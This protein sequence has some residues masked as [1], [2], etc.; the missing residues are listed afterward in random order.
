MPIWLILTLIF[1]SLEVIAVSKSLNRLEYVAKPAVMLCLFIWLYV[2]TGLQGKTFWFGVGLLFSLAGDVLLLS[3]GD[4][5]FLLGLIAF[6]FAHISYIVG[7]SDA[8]TNVESWPVTWMALITISA[9]Y[10]L[11]RIVA[12]LRARGEVK[13]IYPVIIYGAVISFMLF[14]AIS[15]VYDVTWETGAALLA[16]IGAFLFWISDLILAWN[17]FVSPIQNGRTFSIVTYYLG[18]IG[19]IAGVIRQFG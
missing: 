5:T 7:F 11:R 18:Q 6:L 8:L 12:A 4:R 14:G 17:K 9:I 3:S 16:S 1:A 10:L 13:L 19:L 2:S 15:T